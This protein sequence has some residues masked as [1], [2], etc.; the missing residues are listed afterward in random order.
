MI[1][2]TD[3][4]ELL[5]EDMMSHGFLVQQVTNSRLP[6]LLA[7][8]LSTNDVEVGKTELSKPD[9]VSFIA[10]KGT[11]AERVQR[12]L[13]AVAQASDQDKEFAYWLALRKNVDRFE[14]HRA[15]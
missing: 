10:W 2:A 9:Y 14:E 4:I 3:I 7:E 1:T 5:G 6:I 15:P 11:V 12:A 13:A 8:L